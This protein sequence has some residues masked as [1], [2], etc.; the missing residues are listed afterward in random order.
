[1]AKRRANKTPNRL[2]WVIDT[3]PYFV[4]ER[5]MGGVAQYQGYERFPLKALPTAKTFLRAKT[6]YPWLELFAG[7]GEDAKQRLYD[8]LKNFRDTRELDKYIPWL[9]AQLNAA[10]R[11]VKKTAKRVLKHRDKTGKF[12]L[13]ESSVAYDDFMNYSSG[14]GRIGWLS[15]GAIATWAHAT[16]EDLSEWDLPSA[17][18]AAMAWVEEH[19]SEVDVSQGE[20]VYEF[21]D[22]WTIQRLTTQEEFWNET[23]AMGH[24]VGKRDETGCYYYPEELAGIEFDI[25]SPRDPKGKPHATI[26][27][28]L[29]MLEEPSIEQIRGKGNTMPKPKYMGYV[30]CYVAHGMYNVDHD[31]LLRD[32][33]PAEQE[34]AEQLAKAFRVD[35]QRVLVPTADELFHYSQTMIMKEGDLILVVK[36]PKARHR[37]EPNTLA[38]SAAWIE[39]ALEQ[40]D[41]KFQQWWEEVGYEQWWKNVGYSAH[42]HDKFDSEEEFQQ[43]EQE[44]YEEEYR[45]Q[46]ADVIPPDNLNDEVVVA[47]GS[48]A[49]ALWVKTGHLSEEEDPPYDVEFYEWLGTKPEEIWKAYLSVCGAQADQAKRAA[50]K[51]KRRLMR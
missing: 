47:Y 29:R 8:E 9:A 14:E 49:L 19:G 42:I 15:F 36:N 27:L 4:A 1:M 24:C 13:D 28:D 38:L 22:G 10:Y 2:R 7:A 40:F 16:G 43:W 33:T 32:P 51:L 6:A 34:R 41:N 31:P 25:L 20:V 23:Q 17:A 48:S 5:V 50:N 37:G 30:A 39:Y 45:H 21:A 11:P 12:W 44:Q 18:T 46:K 35:L 3:F 26:E